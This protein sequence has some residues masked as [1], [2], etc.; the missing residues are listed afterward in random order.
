MQPIPTNYQLNTS[1]IAADPL[2]REWYRDASEQ[3]Q[4][5]VRTTRSALLAAGEQLVTAFAMMQLGRHRLADGSAREMTND[6]RLWIGGAIGSAACYWIPAEIDRLLQSYPLPPHRFGKRQLPHPRMWVCPELAHGPGDWTVDSFLV[7]AGPNKEGRDGLL[8]WL[9]GDGQVVGSSIP[10]G[11][12]YPE[13]VGLGSFGDILLK[14]LAFLDSPYTESVR[15]RH[16]R[17]DRRAL[18]RAGRE[19]PTVHVVRLRTATRAA[20]EREQEAMIT[21][22]AFRHRWWVRGHFRAQWYP[23][24]QAHR[25]VWI[26]PY[27][28]G[29]EDKPFKASAYAVVR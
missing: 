14:F 16:K 19:E 12:R 28:K 1:A 6:E 17:S 20:V 5:G 4:R 18:E 25:V 23:S 10:W 8:I 7:T 9:I 26:A 15:T 13:E 21:G 24:Q 29:P 27:I 11:S 2:V 22:R 3:M